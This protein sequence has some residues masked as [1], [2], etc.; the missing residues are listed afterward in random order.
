MAFVQVHAT[1]T[2]SS[3]RAAFQNISTNDTNCYIVKDG[4]ETLVIDTGAPS[5]EGFAILDAALTELDVDRT[6][7][8][9]F[10]THL[11]LD[12]AGLVDRLA[13]PGAKLYVSPVDFESVRVARGSSMMR[14]GARSRPRACRRPTRRVRATPELRLFDA[15][16]LELVAPCDGDAI[17]VGR[18]RFRVGDARTRPGTWRSTSPN[19][20]S[21]SAAT[22]CCSSY[23]PASRCSPTERDGLQAY[24]TAWTRCGRALRE[25]VRR[26]R[27]AARRFRRAHRLAARS[28]PGAPGGDVRHRA[29][30]AGLA[31]EEVIRAI[32][33]NVPYPT[34]RRYPRQRWCIVTEG[35]VIL[36]HLVGAALSAARR[37]NRGSTGISK[38]AYPSARR[39]SAPLRWKSVPKSRFAARW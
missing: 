37:T 12:H 32:K 31:G 6:R 13:L 3:A 38:G 18:Y 26:A 22:T 36:N 9:F 34:W 27:R 35:V 10:L 30:P 15:S 2:C 21:C 8:R 23:R 4:D 39:L 1:P 11:H 20:A 17:E 28:P 24:P 33:W 7:M 19:R 29:R 25:T 5:D 14:R 16:R